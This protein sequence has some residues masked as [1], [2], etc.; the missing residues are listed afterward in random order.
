MEPEPSRGNHLLN[1]YMIYL[2]KSIFRILGVFIFSIGLGYAQAPVTGAAPQELSVEQRLAR[3]ERILQGQGLLEM[4]EQLQQLQQEIGLLRGEIET[5]NYNLEQLTRR[6]RDL[7]T[8]VDQRIQRIEGGA[9]PLDNIDTLISDNEDPDGPPLETLSAMPNMNNSTSAIRSDNPLQVEIVDNFS[10]LE[11][12]NVVNNTEPQPT[13]D[14]LV[15]DPV[16]IEV[17]PVTAT[18]VLPVDPV[19]LQAEYQQ[20]FNLLRQSLYDQAIRAFQQFLALHPDDTYSDNAQYW[21]A[22]AFYVKQEY[23]QALEEY[24]NVVDRF[25]QSQKLNDARLK[26]G[27]T[28]YELGEFEAAK[29]QLQELTNNLPGTTI[30]RLADE[31]LKTINSTIPNTVPLSN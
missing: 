15:S 29:N 14:T 3:M 16:N 8:D 23:Q 2:L 30:A 27:F 20:A 10:D 17:S 21:L 4:L 19:Q 13:T 22:E 18:Q 25:P 1:K 31:R 24:N 9:L 28:L 26:I 12:Q 11:T 6:Q 7:Y 5:Q